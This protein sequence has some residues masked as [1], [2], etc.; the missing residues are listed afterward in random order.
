MS[1]HERLAR[2]EHK[3][4]T[5]LHAL[6]VLLRYALENAVMSKLHDDLLASA[7]RI[8]SAT[9]HAMTAADA[10]IAAKT[11]G[12]AA[13]ADVAT[14]MDSAEQKIEALQAKL[15]AAS[16][17]DGSQGSAAGAGPSTA[18]AVTQG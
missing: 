1:E 6:H 5:A 17:E 11:E 12:E 18:T 3:V 2:I 10:V 8:D 16:T 4:D 14:A 9:D 7:H 13:M 15:A